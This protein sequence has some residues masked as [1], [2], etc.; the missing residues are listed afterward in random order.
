MTWMTWPMLFIGVAMVVAGA[1]GV[2][3]DE[4]H[5]WQL[6]RWKRRWDRAQKNRSSGRP[7]RGRR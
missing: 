1:T 3:L 6:R 4:W 7:I 2:A 5:Q